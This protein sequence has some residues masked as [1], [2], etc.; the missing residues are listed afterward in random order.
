MKKKLTRDSFSA[1]RSK[2]VVLN[3]QQQKAFIG[4]GYFE[5]YGIG[6]YDQSGNYY[7]S[8]TQDDNGSIY[9]GDYWDNT[10]SSGSGYSGSGLY[11]SNSITGYGTS[12]NPLSVEDYNTLTEMGR[13]NGGYV[14][15][16]GYVLPEVT[17]LGSTGNSNNNSGTFNINDAIIYLTSNA[18][19]TSSGYCAM[20]VR[21]AIEAGG[22]ST[23]G[24]PGSACGYDTYL[25][26]IGFSVVDPYNYIPQS[27][28][29][30]VHEA[31]SGHPYG[32]IA[33]YNGEK[34]ISDFT[35]SD[36]YGS[37]A[38]RNNP[39]YTILRWNP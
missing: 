33:M 17:V 36:M 39:D 21:Q 3:E 18:Q 8:R 38:Y 13:W 35:Q 5:D 26:T 16:L 29:I 37:S 24:R 2:F 4:G 15:G 23:D 9:S 34:W 30:V 10:S 6:Y 27:G 11:E 19:E 22:L 7:W 32:H 25:P 1:L 31:T 14:E 28:D 20:Y 12:G